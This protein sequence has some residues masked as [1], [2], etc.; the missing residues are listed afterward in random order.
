MD[1]ETRNEWGKF[2]ALA[3]IEEDPDKFLEIRGNLVRMLDEKQA[4]LNRHRPVG[5]P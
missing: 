4:Q 2:C 3:E 1:Y 5:G